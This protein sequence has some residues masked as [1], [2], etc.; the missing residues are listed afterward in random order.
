MIEQL[1]DIA[2]RI[3]INPLNTVEHAAK[4]DTVIKVLSDIRESYN[5]YLEIEFLRNE[6]FKKIY[7]EDKKVLERI[8]ANLGLLVVDLKYSSFE[9]ALAPNFKDFNL[10]LFDD[11]V[12]NWKQ[13]VYCGYK[14]NIISGDYDNEKYLQQIAKKYNE[15][16]RS[17]I[18]KPLFNSFSDGKEYEVILKDKNNNQIKILQQSEKS[19]LFYVSKP[20]KSKSQDTDYNI[21]QLFA[22]VR[23]DDK[24]YKVNLRNILYSEKLEHDTY[25]FKPDLIKY[26][27][28]I[29]VLN[30][31]L[32]C[33]VEFEEG[34]YFIKNNELDIIVWGETRKEVEE[35]FSFSFYSIYLNYYDEED[36]K[37][38]DESILFK[39]ELRKLIKKVI[40]E[41]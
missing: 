39:K 41:A 15:K 40:D 7:D 3:Y 1:K 27:N 32:D 28:K 31:N 20:E 38:S 17:K 22:K 29:F 11:E 16:E 33:V 34:N 18:F 37:L 6:N 36:T 19:K 10:S 2:F 26:Q 35:A 8:K 24:N 25:P 14:D 23:K 5:N 12:N 4:L 13:D 9:A 30:K 21:V